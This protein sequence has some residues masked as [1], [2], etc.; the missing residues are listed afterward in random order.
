MSVV[1]RRVPSALRREYR[2]AGGMRIADAL[3]QADENL[4]ALAPNALVRIDRAVSRIAGLIASPKRPL[5]S[6]D[7]RLAHTLVNE[8]LAC[9]TTVEIPGFVE[10]LYACGRL[11][12]ALLSAE[13]RPHDALSPGVNLLRLAR[14]GSLA[15]QDL[16]ALVEGVD[17]C[18]TRFRTQ[19]SFDRH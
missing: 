4:G 1:V 17:Q 13:H 19:G 3:A 10:A 16:E 7:L 18:A 2:K 8:M 5:T 14:R 9:C 12:A 11:I 15:S 6:D